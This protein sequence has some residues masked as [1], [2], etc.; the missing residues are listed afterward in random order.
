[1][2]LRAEISVPGTAWLSF[3]ARPQPHNQTLLVK[4]NLFAPRGL[5][6]ALSW[7]LLIPNPQPR[8]SVGAGDRLVRRHHLR[9]C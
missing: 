2:R 8:L 4:S 5:W 6:G 7:I 1:M 9:V 3:E